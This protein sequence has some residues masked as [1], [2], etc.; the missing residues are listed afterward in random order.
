MNFLYNHFIF[1]SVGFFLGGGVMGTV[2]V[3]SSSRS[4]RTYTRMCIHYNLSICM[5]VC[6]AQ[7]QCVIIV[8]TIV[9]VVI[10]D[11][12][13]PKFFYGSSF[14]HFPSLPQKLLYNWCFPPSLSDIIHICRELERETKRFTEGPRRYK[15]A[16]VTWYWNHR[17][18]MG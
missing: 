16:A 3:L 10:V 12:P 5:C 17:I 2:R 4:T 9:M 7:R 8:T 14:N 13:V 18:F 11:L 6:I 15:L 1:H